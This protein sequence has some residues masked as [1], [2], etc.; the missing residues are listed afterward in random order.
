MTPHLGPIASRSG[1]PAPE[2]PPVS[3]ITFVL[4]DEVTDGVA[5][6]HD[7][8]TVWQERS[9]DSLGQYLRHIAPLG[10][11]VVLEIEG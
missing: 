4:W 8:V 3:K 2:A 1:L 11:P 5:V 10:R 9:F 6:Q 7:G